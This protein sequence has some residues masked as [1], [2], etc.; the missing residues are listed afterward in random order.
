MYL[1]DYPVSS[2]IESVTILQCEVEAD[3]GEG[4]DTYLEDRFAQEE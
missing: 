2:H 1:V 3:E 4:F